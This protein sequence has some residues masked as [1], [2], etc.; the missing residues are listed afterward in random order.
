MFSSSTVPSSTSTPTGKRQ[1]AQRHDVDRLAGEPKQHYRHQQ[2]ERNR[3]DDDERDCASRAE[4]AR[5]SA[6][7]GQRTDEA[8]A[9]HGEKRVAHI[10]RL[11]K[12]VGDLDV[13]R[14]ERLKS[15]E[16]LAHFFTTV[17][18]EASGRL[19]TGM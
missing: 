12:F 3:D 17:S 19:V 15:F 18:V 9:Q 10:L 5:S 11:I 1:S 14:D 16:I 7:S 6:R 13:F 4:T 2:R 8:F